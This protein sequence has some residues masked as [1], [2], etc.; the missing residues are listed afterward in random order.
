VIH[1]SRGQARNV[2]RIADRVTSESS[3]DPL[4]FGV[5][6]LAIHSTRDRVAVNHR[7][8]GRRR[9]VV[10]FA[11]HRSPEEWPRKCYPPKCSSIP[12][13]PA[14]FISLRFFSRLDGSSRTCLLAN[15]EEKGRENSLAYIE[16]NCFPSERGPYGMRICKISQYILSPFLCF[17]KSFS[18]RQLL[19]NTAGRTGRQQNISPR[20]RRRRGVALRASATRASFLFCRNYFP[21]RAF[22]LISAPR[23]LFV[24]LFL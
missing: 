18:A 17:A 16:R 12:L 19:D 6:Q 2:R 1:F 10:S 7:L 13:D 20:R 4:S 23:F 11:D 14:L 9:F 21:G 3:F 8:I 5:S 22:C 24:V 15:S